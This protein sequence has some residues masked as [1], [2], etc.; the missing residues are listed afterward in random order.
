MLLS[1]FTRPYSCTT[2]SHLIFPTLAFS[3]QSQAA[4][5]AHMFCQFQIE[6]HHKAHQ[7]LFFCTSGLINQPWVYIYTD[8]YMTAVIIVIISCKLTQLEETVFRDD[9][10]QFDLRWAQLPI[11]WIHLWTSSVFY[12]VSNQSLY[13]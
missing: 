3:L 5:L 4:H 1:W 8:D 6:L 11:L 10:G 9:T 2:L 12:Y 13:A 7:T